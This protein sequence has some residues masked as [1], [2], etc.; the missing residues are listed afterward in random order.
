M[1]KMDEK[2]VDADVTL[3]LTDEEWEEFRKKYGYAMLT[4]AR[5]TSVEPYAYYDYTMEMI[6]VVV[7]VFMAFSLLVAVF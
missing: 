3:R 6:F 1:K 7:F 2:R 4:P 5:H